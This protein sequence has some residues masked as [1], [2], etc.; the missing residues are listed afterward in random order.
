[1]QILVRIV[2]DESALITVFAF[3]VQ[4]LTILNITPCMLFF[5]DLPTNRM[6][7]L[8]QKIKSRRKT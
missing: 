4:L 5:K 7:A 6:L 8:P 1:M 3:E 2:I